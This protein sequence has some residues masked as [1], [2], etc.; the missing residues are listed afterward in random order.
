MDQLDAPLAFGLL[1]GIGIEGMERPPVTVACNSP[2]VRKDAQILLKVC[3]VNPLWGKP[4]KIG[5]D[6]ACQL[7]RGKF[8]PMITPATPDRQAQVQRVLIL[9]LA[10]N[11]LVFAI[12]LILGLLTGS[13]SLIAD[14]LHSSSDS[15]SNILGILAMHFSSPDPDE[16][17]PY[18][19]TKFEA[20]GAL[21]I[22]AFLGMACFEII[23]SA[24]Q[25]FFQ[26]DPQITIDD[27]SLHLMVGVLFI[28]IAVTAYEH[29]QG[30]ALA[31]RILL[32]D[33]RHTLG[34][35]WITLAVLGGLIGV[36]MGWIWL[37]QLLAFPVAILVFWSGWE[38]LR[39]NIPFLTDTVAIPPKQLRDL[40][41]SVEGVLDCHEI[42]SRG[43]L[44]QM[45]FIEMHMVVEPIDIDT[46][47]KITEDVEQRLRERYGAVRITIHLEPYQYIEVDPEPS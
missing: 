39:E 33:A 41:L 45:V 26:E 47:H 27:L 13:L 30:K 10:L 4:F 40:V 44:G 1:V 28:N 18:G 6:L 38:V 5:G 37:D 29:H 36:R 43:V 31:S 34:D 21:G 19:H 35:I 17:H 46:A 11:L 16:E 12:K 2:F 24:V 42:T 9:T 23:Q 32:A 25:R 14:A 15:A 20:I 7:F 8:R 3:Q 22:A